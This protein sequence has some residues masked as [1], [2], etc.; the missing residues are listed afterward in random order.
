MVI[1]STKTFL[2]HSGAFPITHCQFVLGVGNNEG[3]QVVNV[4]TPAN[5]TGA[6]PRAESKFNQIR[7]ENAPFH[8]VV[9]ASAITRQ[10]EVP[11]TSEIPD[12]VPAN[13]RSTRFPPSR[14]EQFDTTTHSPS[15]RWGLSAHWPRWPKQ[16]HKSYIVFSTLYPSSQMIVP[17]V[18]DALGSQADKTLLY[19][20]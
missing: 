3:V 10:I 1:F 2:P 18:T 4:L 11:G 8:V 5:A 12:A 14:F 19:S 7:H 16:T 6:A 9:S 17:I 20:V 15:A 13:R